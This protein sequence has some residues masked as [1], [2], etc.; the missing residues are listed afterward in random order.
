VFLVAVLPSLAAETDTRTEGERVTA[1]GRLD[2]VLDG[3]LDLIG[4]L[5]V[6]LPFRLDD[7]NS[8][9]LSVASRTTLE[10][11][12]GL[13]FKVRDLQYDLGLGWRGRP[14]GLR[15]SRISGLIGQRGKE[16]VDA[17]GQAFVRYL[18]FGLESSEFR[19]YRATPR[20][21][22]TRC[23]AGR[24]F[25]WRFV[26]GPVVED[27]EVEADA[28]LN[29][30]ASLWLA[31]LSRPRMAFAL[32]FGVDGLLDGGDFDADVGGGPRISFPVA[33]GRRA[34]FFL[35]YRSGGNPLGVG[36]PLWLLGFAYDEGRDAPPSGPGAPEIDGRVALGAGEGRTAGQLRLRFLSPGIGAGVR[37]TIV[38]DANI[39]TA[40]ETGDLY[41]FWVAGI[42]REDRASIYG[43][44]L[45]H[46]S[47]HQLAEPNAFVTSLNVLE[48]G[49]ETRSWQRP[50]RSSPGTTW[51]S[52]D[53]RAR[54]GLLLESSFGEDP[55]WHFRGGVRWSL[56]VR[57]GAPLP[58]LLAELETGDVDRRL[59]AAGLNFLRDLELQLEY[60]SD[61]QYFARD[62]R[63][64]L[65]AVRYWF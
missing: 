22:E 17:D 55:R 23:G 33:G 15:G 2:W 39:L 44:Y 46:R 49:Y 58:Y 11:P 53:G 32:D 10:Q 3:E 20:C 52:I 4:D 14:A 36:E 47:N 30:E 16:A 45:Y 1:G 19:A 13:T 62:K 60:R 51:G 50:A 5:W 64:L 29:G 54:V 35:H 59:Y 9:F 38:I 7:R 57:G 6:D 41:Y 63:A 48:L 34:S 31:S 37:A 8:V 40:E 24:R 43:A 28:V 26:L 27:R 25:D 42:E 12:D 61:D 21:A 18:A 65:L 56:P